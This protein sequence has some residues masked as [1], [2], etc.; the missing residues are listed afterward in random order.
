MPTTAWNDQYS[1]RRGKQN[2][3]SVCCQNAP[4][5]GASNAVCPE[6]RANWRAAG[7]QQQRGEGSDRIYLQAGSGD[8]RRGVRVADANNDIKPN[9][10]LR[11]YDERSPRFRTLIRFYSS[12]RKTEVTD[13]SYVDLRYDGSGSSLSPV[14]REESTYNKIR[15]SAEQ[16]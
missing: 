8:D 16:Q 11:R 15:H 14:A 10:P 9:L 4:V 3:A 5:P 13:I 2:T 1:G 12:R 6:A 7:Y